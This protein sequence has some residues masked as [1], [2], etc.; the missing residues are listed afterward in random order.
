VTLSSQPQWLPN[1]KTVP[2]SIE[3]PD[4]GLVA[5]VVRSRDEAAFRALYRRHTPALYRLALRLLRGDVTRADDAMQDTWLRAVGGLSAFAWRSSLRTW[6]CGIAVNVCREVVRAELRLVESGVDPPDG[7]A[8]PD[9]HAAL[10]L[11]RALVALPAAYREVLVLHDVEGFTHDEIGE[12]LAIPPGT[13]KSH[14]FRAR[15]ELRATLAG[16]GKRDRRGGPR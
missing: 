10:D 14:L 6:L 13:S 16:P 1:R 11:E 15:R 8:S 9:R 12:L 5:A 3:D 4:R 2:G 7:D